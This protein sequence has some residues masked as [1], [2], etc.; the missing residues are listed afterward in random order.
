[1]KALEHYCKSKINFMAVVYVG[2]IA[3]AVSLKQF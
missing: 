1:M 3:T 2:L